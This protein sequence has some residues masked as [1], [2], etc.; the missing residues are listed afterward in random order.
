MAERMVRVDDIELWTED[1]GDRAKPTL[2]AVMGATMQGI[3]CPEPFC[4]MLAGGGYHVVR[5]D[6]RDT[7]RSTCLDFGSQPYD[8][9]DLAAD[10]L[11]VLD[12]YGVRAA[13]V[14]GVSM[15]GMIGQ[16]LA[17]E[18]PD[19]VLTLTSIMSSPSGIEIGA[20]F[21]GRDA[22][23]GLPGPTPELIAAFGAAYAV[24]PVDRASAIE[25]RIAVARA[26]AGSLA[27]F[28]EEAE[29][30]LV[31]ECWD[32]ATDW[33]AADHHL[34]A[35]DAGPSRLGRLGAI[36]CPTLVVHGTEDPG[37]PL[38]HGEATA[39]AIPGA[40]LL[41]IAGMGHELPAAVWP[42]VTRAI[43]DLAG[44]ASRPGAS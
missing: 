42:D 27:P 5:Y 12:A 35:I 18:H 41:P 20:G 30:R 34:E 25:A 7:G 6:H 44:T 40:V 37:L 9:R 10:A 21:A 43:L 33:A 16:L 23:T 36:G 15:G 2:L 4:R 19:R 14:V 28:D 17:L 8:L 32:R 31:G 1:F 13:H 11:G 22:G 39:A 24:P 26:A 3:Q 38:A 29:R